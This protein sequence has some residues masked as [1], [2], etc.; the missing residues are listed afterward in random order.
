MRPRARPAGA[1]T[2]RRRTRSSPVP[3]VHLAPS[4]TRPRRSAA[5]PAA[6]ARTPGSARPP[7]SPSLCRRSAPPRATGARAA[8]GRAGSSGALVVACC[9]ACTSAGRHWRSARSCRW[10]GEGARAWSTTA[11]RRRGASGRPVAEPWSACSLSQSMAPTLNEETGFIPFFIKSYSVRTAKQLGIVLF[12]VNFFPLCK[13][14]HR[15]R[16]MSPFF[17]R[18]RKSHGPS[19]R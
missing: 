9:R 8:P 3:F 12:K 16:K 10:A 18:P 19:I 5:S 13:Q 1:R 7:R 15:C 17:E 2:C 4:R 14:A 6:T 11:I